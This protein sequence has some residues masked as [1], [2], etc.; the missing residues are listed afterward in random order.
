M[1]GIDVSSHLADYRPEIGYY[2]PLIG[3][4]IE[5][6]IKPSTRL[7]W[8]ESPGSMTMEVQ[9][10][11]AIVAASHRRGAVVALDNTWAA[12]VLFD[13]FRHGVDVS[14]QAL[15]KYVGGHSDL[16]LGSVSVRDEDA[17]QRVGTTLQH[18]GMVASP[19]DCSLALRG[20][21]TLAVRLSTIESSALTIAGWL[22]NREEIAIVLHPALFSCPGHDVWARDFS[23]S[24]GVFSVVFRPV[25]NQSRIQAFIDRLKLFRIGYS[26]GGVTSLVALP[27]ASESPNTMVYGDRLLRLS[28]GLENTDDLIADLA[29]AMSTVAL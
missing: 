17:Y 29:A 16:L 1:E 2:Q 10:V 9:D 23:G 15:T 26:W 11:P 14:I 20:L 4:S 25:I 12:G 18:L 24:S 13:A 27:D 8:C 19:D 3:G 6:L 5:K 28:I 21:Q 7:V 22:A